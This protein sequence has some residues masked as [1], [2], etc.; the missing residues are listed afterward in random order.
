MCGEPEAQAVVWQRGKAVGRTRQARLQA[1]VVAG[2]VVR[3]RAVQGRVARRQAAT[4]Q[5]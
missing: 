1:T 2:V 3:L 5:A 4:V